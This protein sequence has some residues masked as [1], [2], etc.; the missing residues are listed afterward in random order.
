MF[1]KRDFEDDDDRPRKSKKAAGILVKA[2]HGAGMK[3]KIAAGAG[4]LLMIAYFICTVYIEPDEYGIKVV[5]IG[6]HRGVQKKIYGPGLHLVI[7]G[8]QSM[9]A[10]P[11]NQQVLE[12]TKYQDSAALGARVE[13]AAHIQTSDGFFVDVDA[14]ILY[15]VEDPYLTFTKIGPGKLFEDN[16]IVPKA[17]PA[18]KATLGKLT[19][20]DFFNSPKRVAKGNEAKEHLNAELAVKGIKV[21]QVLIRYFVYSPEIQRNIEEK[22]LKDQ[23]VFTNM[24]RAAAAKEAALVTKTEEEGKANVAVRLEEGQAYV[25]RKLGEIEQYQRTKRAEANLLVQLAEAGKVK[26]RNE[27]LQGAGAERMVGLKM[28]DVY[29]GLETIILPSDGA[30]GINPLDLDKDLKL[31][32]IREGK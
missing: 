10:L 25:A 11:R 17:E 31:F 14:S 9:F 26:L 24:S 20:E 22:K 27:A 28:A 29:K 2:L 13:K 12:L 8:M 5:K 18:L 7:P 15:H 16:G 3:L 1:K 23:L 4:L 32:D 30:N 21:D 19:T 6:V